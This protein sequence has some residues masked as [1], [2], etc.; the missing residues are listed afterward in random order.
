MSSNWLLL[1]LF[2][3][4]YGCDFATSAQ[5]D[6]PSVE[7]QYGAEPQ[8]ELFKPIKDCAE[9]P[10]LVAVP[11]PSDANRLL[12]VGQYEVTWEEYLQSV[13]SS[14]C[15]L[16][17]APPNTSCDGKLDQIADNFPITSL[18]PKNFGN[19]ILDKADWI[20]PYTAY[21]RPYRLALS[22]RNQRP[23]SSG[24]HPLARWPALPSLWVA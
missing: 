11:S 20:R 5:L 19:Y 21:D 12:Y 13:R 15:P 14:G 8:P 4:M 24:K 6:K 18:S 1:L 7:E 9:C 10:S 2:N 16:P 23:R 3:L 22:K 17:E